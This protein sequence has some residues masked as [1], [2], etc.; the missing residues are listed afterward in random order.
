MKTPQVPA[1]PGMTPLGMSGKN[2][3]PTAGAVRF[4]VADGNVTNGPNHLYFSDT[5]GDQSGDYY[6]AA[7]VQAMVEAAQSALEI[8]QGTTDYRNGLVATELRAILEI[9]KGGSNG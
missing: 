2:T 1:I 4:I 7:Q 9:M 8:I 5:P 3:T 6:P